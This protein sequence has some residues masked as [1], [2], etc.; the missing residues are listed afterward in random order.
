VRLGFRSL[1][2]LAS[3]AMFG[4][5]L[6]AGGL[7]LQSQL[8]TSTTDTLEADLGTRTALAARAAEL[9]GCPS[10]IPEAQALARDL[11]DRAGMRVTLIG[12]DGRVLGDSDRDVAT[13]ALMDNHS[14]RPE[15]LQARD[16]GSGRAHRYSRSLD[17]VMLYHARLSGCDSG[18]RYVRGALPDTQ[19][20]AARSQV[21]RALAVSA[22]VA[23]L[24]SALLSGIASSM[25]AANLRELLA[26]AR[27]LLREAP[28]PESPAVE[29]LEDLRGTLAQVE[30][31]VRASID[32]LA[33]Q[34]GLM[35]E[36][37]D[38]LGEAVVAFDRS[39]RTVLV[40]PTARSMLELDNKG[41]GRTAAELLRS[42]EIVELVDSA[43]SG[44][45]MES[46]VTLERAQR[47]ELEA[48]AG[49]LPDGGTLLVLRDLTELRRLEKVRQ[50]FVA[51][52]SHEL[53]T[54]VAT[55]Q[56][57]AETLVD[58]ALIDPVAGP[59]FSAAIH[60]NARR[61][62]DLLNDLLELSRLDAGQRS[63]ASTPVE[64]APLVAE[65]AA[66]LEPLR[67]ARDTTLTLEIPQRTLVQAD[68]RALERVLA[69]LLDNALRHGKEGGAVRMVASLDEGLCRIE[70]SD[71][72][73]GIPSDQQD[74]VFER[75]Y[76]IDAARSRQRGGTG[77]GLSIARHLTESMGGRIG[78]LNQDHGGAL[79]WVEI[80]AAPG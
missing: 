31:E 36:V 55:I 68:P 67:E 61:L 59:D 7:A 32:E 66:A 16:S 74:R 35:T 50:D 56:A 12:R 27:T 73:P 14:Q 2:F 77:L 47:R 24:L 57:H 48:S 49:P 39:G 25:L 34:R 21:R 9:A 64:L 4:F 6:A 43:R 76:R 13:V 52:V 78:V 20:R 79:F 22:V 51:N 71:D 37:L 15:V 42:P 40:N 19:V 17:V 63:L 45:R 65:V 3:L 1:I 5:A 26:H 54:P 28:E 72:G 46:G 41:L 69:N 8:S 80:P 38:A 53:R 58:G 18:P 30:G 60:R 29:S 62:S 11:A 44:E 10:E 33:T 70:V 23:L 75:F